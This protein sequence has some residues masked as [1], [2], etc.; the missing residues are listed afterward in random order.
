MKLLNYDLLNNHKSQRLRTIE[1]TNCERFWITHTFVCD[2]TQIVVSK[3]PN[4]GDTSTGTTQ[5]NSASI[6][7]AIMMRSHLLDSSLSYPVH[8]NKSWSLAK[9]FFYSHYLFQL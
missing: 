3:Q 9:R 7:E 1:E 5:S 2:M 4:Y 6:K 8:H